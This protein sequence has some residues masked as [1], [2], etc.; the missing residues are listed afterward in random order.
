MS[1]Y[2]FIL[3][4]KLLSNYIH[5]Q[6]DILT[7]DPVKIASRGSNFSHLFFVDDLTL[8]A[9]ANS[10]TIHTMYRVVSTFCA[11]SGAKIDLEKSKSLHSKTYSSN[12]K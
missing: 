11:L 8:I 10:K 4:M 6:V 3:C 9:Q 1:P 12:T 7:W 5:Y 2:I